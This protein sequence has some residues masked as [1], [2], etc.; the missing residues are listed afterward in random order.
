MSKRG[1]AVTLSGSPMLIVTLILIVLLLGAGAVAIQ[2]MRD[3][4]DNTGTASYTDSNTFAAS[5]TTA[6][7]FGDY[8]SKSNPAVT[9]A[10]AVFYNGT[11][12]VVVTGNMT[13]SGTGSCYA[14]SDATYNGETI[15]VNYTVSLTTY[16]YA[17]NVSEQGLDTSK[18]FSDQL[19]TVGTM[20]GVALILGVVFG[21]F[22]MFRR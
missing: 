11:N 13:L 3:S 8:D 12:E 7:Y 20:I 6:T 9:C 4:S 16:K 15:T 18:N 1:Q 19:P 5:N 2:S 14:T 17:Y 10:S 22:V 21:I